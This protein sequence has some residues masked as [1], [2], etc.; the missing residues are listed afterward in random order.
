LRLA[1]LPLRFDANGSAWAT[2]AH[3]L[4]PKGG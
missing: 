1:Q 4:D 2:H 3:G